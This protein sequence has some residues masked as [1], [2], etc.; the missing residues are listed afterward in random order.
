M[1]EIPEEKTPLDRF[2][3]VDEDYTNGVRKIQRERDDA[4]E[5]L[6]KFLSSPATETR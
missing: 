5:K 4:I 3:T 2:V 1:I 6:D